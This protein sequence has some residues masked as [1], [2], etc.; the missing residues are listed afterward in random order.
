LV[1][2]KIGLKYSGQHLSPCLMLYR[3][4][5]L[6]TASE[7]DRPRCLPK[8]CMEELVEV[9][10][11]NYRFMFRKLLWREEFLIPFPKGKDQMRIYL[12][13]A[14]KEVSGLPVT[15]LAEATRI[16]E[17][18]PTAISSRVFRIYKGQARA[19]RKFEAVGLYKAPEPNKFRV[20][21]EE[22]EDKTDQLAEAARLRLEAQFGH[23]ELAEAASVDKQ[24]LKASK[25]RG[26]IKVDD[27]R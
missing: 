27:D 9:D 18:L 5:V 20:L 13:H 1:P 6:E 25:M 23:R 19:N 26:A 4:R 12:A 10:L 8:G 7:I 24:I 17:S 2:H 15:S 3:Y 16:M 22:E 14:L 21:I 11:L